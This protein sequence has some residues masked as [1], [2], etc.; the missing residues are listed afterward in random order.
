MVVGCDLFAH[1]PC[2]ECWRKPG[3]NETLLWG[4]IHLTEANVEPKLN[5]LGPM[6]IGPPKIGAEKMKYCSLRRHIHLIPPSSS[7]FVT[8]AISGQG[9]GPIKI[10][11]HET[12]M[13]ADPYKDTMEQ[14]MIPYYKSLPDRIIFQQ[15][16]ARHHT[17]KSVLSF[18]KEQRVEIMK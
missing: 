12:T 16:G 9:R 6:F 3:L 15:D 1:V 10:V 2:A 5:G 17:A 4:C 11:A 13:K 14:I 18:L 7:M 8:G